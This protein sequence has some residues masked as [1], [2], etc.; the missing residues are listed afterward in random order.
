[1]LKTIVDQTSDE[2]QTALLAAVERWLGRLRGSNVPPQLHDGLARYLGAGVHPGSFLTGL[3]TGDNAAAIVRADQDCRAAYG[4]IV[5]W[6]FSYAPA[7]SWGS[8]GNVAEWRASFTETCVRC[9]KP[10]KDR[11][12]DGLCEGCAQAWA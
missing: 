10:S 8:E 4:E 12:F 9:R 2:R 1:M 3:L 11:D 7:C 5:L 6:L